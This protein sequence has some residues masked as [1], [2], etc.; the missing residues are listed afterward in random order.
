MPEAIE[1][2]EYDIRQSREKGCAQQQVDVYAGVSN[3]CGVG[4]NEAL[5][6]GHLH[7][8]GENGEKLFADGSGA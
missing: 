7:D 4:Q 8:M 3:A 2:S 5:L 6:V 1:E